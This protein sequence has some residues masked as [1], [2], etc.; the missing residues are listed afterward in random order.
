MSEPVVLLASL[1]VTKDAHERATARPFI[2]LSRA[3]DEDEISFDEQDVLLSD[4]DTEENTYDGTTGRW[5]LRCTF[6]EDDWHEANHATLTRFLEQLAQDG[7]AGV[8]FGYGAWSPCLVWHVRDGGVRHD[9]LDAEQFPAS[10]V[11]ALG[12]EKWH[13][14]A[15][16][17]LDWCA[18][19]A[20]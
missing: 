3:I 11:E 9:E 4:M 12:D 8:V 1:A 17:M 14:A 7:G 19:R 15:N 13:D 16:A 18:G 10:V 6:H 2:G 20:R 5:Q